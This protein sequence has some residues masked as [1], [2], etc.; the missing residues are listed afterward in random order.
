MPKP[1]SLGRGPRHVAPLPVV[2]EPP[3]NLFSKSL[4]AGPA[5]LVGL[6]R[7]WRQADHHVRGVVRGLVGG[8]VHRRPRGYR[9][10]AGVHGAGR[11]GGQRVVRVHRAA[12]ARPRETSWVLLV[13]NR[14][15][16]SSWRTAT[17]RAGA[18]SKVTEARVT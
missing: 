12:V 16:K 5:A 4:L 9:R 18:R 11:R 8:D 1:D 3:M 2:V 7:S 14:G 13:E 6:Y 10:G 15:E 17:T